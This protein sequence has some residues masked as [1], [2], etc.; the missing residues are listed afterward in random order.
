[1][2][3]KI[4]IVARHFMGG[5]LTGRTF[6]AVVLA[7]NEHTKLLFPDHVRAVGASSAGILVAS[8]CRTSPGCSSIRQRAD[9]AVGRSRSR[10]DLGQRPRTISPAIPG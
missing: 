7:L 2:N 3:R 8:P 4:K 6:H 10:D 9:S 1:M 5:L